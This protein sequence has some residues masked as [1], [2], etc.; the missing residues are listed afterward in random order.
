M[1]IQACPANRGG[2]HRW[3]TKGHGVFCSRC[4]LPLHATLLMTQPGRDGPTAVIPRRPQPKADLTIQY[5]P[6]EAPYLNPWKVCREN[7]WTHCF[8]C[9]LPFAE[10]RP[11][12][13]DH[14]IPKSAGGTRADGLVYACQTCNS[15]RGNINFGRYVEASDAEHETAAREGREYRRPKYRLVGTEYVLTTM[16]RREI[17]EARELVG[18]YF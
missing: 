8:W 2:E 6:P 15:A 5:P 16:T 17:R 4:D 9:R 1:D 11:P 14:M 7:G 13:A 12:T 3:R 18:K 10:G